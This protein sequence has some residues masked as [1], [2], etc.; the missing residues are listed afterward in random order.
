M[1]QDDLASIAWAAQRHNVPR[2]I[3]GALFYGQ[4][5]FLQVI[6]GE[7]SAVEG[8]FTRVLRDDR[9]TDLVCIS[10]KHVHFRLFPTCNTGVFNLEEHPAP[11]NVEKL[12]QLADAVT[13]TGNPEQ[14][15][16]DIV[17]FIEEFRRQVCTVRTES[18]VAQPL[19]LHHTKCR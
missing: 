14:A 19:Q 12:V 2:K 3:T 5:R 17:D 13:A 18:L 7:Q 10:G 11:I 15:Y 4:W 1:T 8:L 16:P 6:E 9:H